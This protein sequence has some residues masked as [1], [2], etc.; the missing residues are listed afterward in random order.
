M[1]LPSL[2]LK[3]TDSIVTVGFGGLD[4]RPKPQNSSL[5]DAENMSADAYPALSP[6][7]S[8][9]TVIAERG[10]RTAA[11]PSYTGDPL[12]AFTGVKEDGFYY[13]GTKINGTLSE[14]EKSIVD[15]N[16]TFCIFPDKLSYRYL[17][18]PTDGTVGTSLVSMEKTLTVKGITF[19]SSLNSVSGEYTAYL[20]KSGAG[21]D[22]FSVGESIV[23]S[24]T[25]DAQNRV[26]A[27]KSRSDYAAE[28]AIVSAVVT[29]SSANRLDLLLY[30]KS[31]QKAL[32]RNGSD[33]GS[34]TVKVSIPDMNH[35]CIHNN[36]L[37]GTDPNGEYLYASKPGDPTNFHSFQGLSDDSWY[38]M[39]GTAGTF[40]GIVAYRSSV[41]ALKQ[42]CIHHVYGDAPQN[43]AI[44]K[45]TYGGCIDGKSIAELNGVL[46]YLS[47][48]GFYAYSGGE[49]YPVG[50]EL[51]IDY[52]SAAAGCDGVRY[53]AAAVRADGTRDLLVYHPEHGVWHREDSTAFSQFFNFGNALYGVTD[54]GILQFRSG[55]ERVCWSFTTQPTSYDTL[56]HK[57]VRNLRLLLDTDPD[58]TV[59]VSISHDGDPFVP[60]ANL[61][62]TDGTKSHRIPIR[63][64]SCD[65]FRIRLEGEGRAVIHALELSVYQG[66]K[67]YDL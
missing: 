3:N 40:T 53:Y 7:K 51:P 1:F 22:R 36:R 52:R 4:L 55:D 42:N 41:V 28:D 32:F 57:G 63:F 67:T 8:R 23:I 61:T 44:P 14:G 37:W 13:Q 48:A 26:V 2:N 12:S 49:P 39:I 29:A 38:S 19:Y 54:T 24:G 9:Q 60:S 65:T 5:S 43:Y 11:V 46:Y 56:R 21:F 45:Q 17:P 35:V 15:F 16:G 66:G 62:Q 31:G 6:R 47:H 33:S 10:I 50:Q 27:L 59:T 20:S 18:D 58:T 25:S 34:V 64:R 30:T